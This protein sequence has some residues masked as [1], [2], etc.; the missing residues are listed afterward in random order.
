MIKRKPVPNAGFLVLSFNQSDV[1][2]IQRNWNIESIWILVNITNSN[3]IID[4]SDMLGQVWEDAITSEILDP[5]G[6]I[7]LGSFSFKI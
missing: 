5:T 2:I 3:K 7:E 4:P 6:I 1:V